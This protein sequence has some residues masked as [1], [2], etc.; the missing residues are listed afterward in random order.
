MTV[1]EESHHPFVQNFLNR[2][3]IPQI[4]RGKISGQKVYFIHGVRNPGT[5]LASGTSHPVRLF[6]VK[7]V[8]RLHLNAQQ[9]AA[10]VDDEVVAPAVS[11]RF[12]YGQ[13]LR[14][15][16]KNKRQFAQVSQ[17]F[18]AKCVSGMREATCG[19][20]WS[21]NISFFI[22]LVDCAHALGMSVISP[23][24]SEFLNV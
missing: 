24:C 8:H 7:P 22:H 2:D 1:G 14:S 10:G 16:S 21:A 6:D 3:D 20:L 4:P 13:A 18:A 12:G 9:A 5:A 23:L 17:F 19:A 11:V 15:G